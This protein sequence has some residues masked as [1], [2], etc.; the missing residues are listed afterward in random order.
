KVG[1]LC[2]TLWGDVYAGS[3]Y[4]GVYHSSDNGV[5]WEH[6]VDSLTCLN[7]NGLACDRAGTIYAATK[8]G[9]F[10]Y[11]STTK[12]WEDISEGLGTRDIGS[13]CVTRQGKLFVGT[14]GMGVY[15][16]KEQVAS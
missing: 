11:H 2:S 1:S 12:I 15:K 3:P 7:V 4:Q 14:N 10:R 16:F 5:T 8:N 9:V 13:V 6:I